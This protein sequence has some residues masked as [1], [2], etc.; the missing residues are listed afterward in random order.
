MKDSS[1][2]AFSDDDTS[3]PS[4]A[5]LIQQDSASTQQD[6]PRRVAVKRVSSQS[7]R[8]GSNKDTSLS[9]Q[10]KRS[11]VE[12]V[13]AR[14]LS[15]QE[16]LQ[17]T[18][19]LPAETQADEGKENRKKIDLNDSTLLD[20]DEYLSMIRKTSGLS[21]DFDGTAE[22]NNVEAIKDPFLPQSKEC[23]LKPDDASFL[24]VPS[25]QPLESSKSSED[26]DNI[27]S[28]LLNKLPQ[29]SL[30][31]LHKDDD[32]DERCDVSVFRGDQVECFCQDD[33]G[34]YTSADVNMDVIKNE[35]IAE[36]KQF[37]AM[38]NRMVGMNCC[39]SA[40]EKNKYLR[41][42]LS[43][44][45]QKVANIVDPG[46]KKYRIMLQA[47]NKY[48]QNLWMD[49]ADN[50]CQL[51]ML[52][53]TIG[54]LPAYRKLQKFL[55]HLET[56]NSEFLENI[57]HTEEVDGSLLHNVFVDLLS[58]D[59]M[60]FLRAS[61]H[62]ATKKGGKIH[63]LVQWAIERFSEDLAKEVI[64]ESEEGELLEDVDFRQT[65]D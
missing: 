4:D 60:E 53:R 33:D 40:R 26:E 16:A 62:F 65:L 63:V 43:P 51:L 22:T 1:D 27:G 38:F 9:P 3:L 49:N 52:P 44:G 19:T 45:A 35:S 28:M 21:K 58:D 41:E 57:I 15:F 46:F 25:L 31:P 36:W 48:F 54:P 42:R 50:L 39:F 56:F 18:V 59:E 10:F 5:S 29:R 20:A 11:K 14:V 13:Q 32:L 61:E 30:F 23:K 55:R 47:V 37:L 2:P 8:T 6:K 64:N 12:D 17:F 34:T 7:R 24:V